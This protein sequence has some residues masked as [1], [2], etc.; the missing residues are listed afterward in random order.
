MIRKKVGDD[1]KVLLADL[2]HHHIIICLHERAGRA[3]QI[4]SRLC[5]RVLIRTL[6]ESIMKSEEPCVSHFFE[7]DSNHDGPL[8]TIFPDTKYK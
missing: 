4:F 3:R 8:G 6:L 7:K 1:E 2:I 5:S